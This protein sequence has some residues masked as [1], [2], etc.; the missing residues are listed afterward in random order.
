MCNILKQ[1]G[2]IF[3]Q[4]QYFKKNELESENNFERW[5]YVLKRMEAFTKL[6]GT[7]KSPTFK[8]ESEINDF[9]ALSK[10]EH[11]KYFFTIYRDK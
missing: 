10:E 7:S 4:L 6:P 11:M 5:I 1:I 3:L 9:S 8:N 2:L